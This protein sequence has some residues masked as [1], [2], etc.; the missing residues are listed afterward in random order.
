MFCYY[1]FELIQV[2]VLIFLSNC[3]EHIL[4]LYLKIDDELCLS[5][6]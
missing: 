4:F 6:V 3:E 2:F 1:N 5:D